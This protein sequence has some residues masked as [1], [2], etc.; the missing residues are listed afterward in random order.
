MR[1]GGASACARERARERERAGAKRTVETT[2]AQF[3][4]AAFDAWTARHNPDWVL[5]DNTPGRETHGFLAQRSEWMMVYWSEQAIVWLRRDRYPALQPLSFRLLHPLLPMES[6]AQ[7]LAQAA[8][9]PRPMQQIGDEIQRLIDASPQSLRAQS[10][11][12]LYW[13]SLGPAGAAQADQVWDAML[14]VH[15]EHPAMPA[16]AQQFGRT[17]P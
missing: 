17:P 5:A 14:E 6:I 2:R 13:S 11:A 4:P 12:L 9:R 8:G 16:L 7:A 15:A 10:L 1:V 3:D